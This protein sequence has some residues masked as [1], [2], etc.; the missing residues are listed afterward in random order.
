MPQ[1]LLRTAFLDPSEAKMASLLHFQASGNLKTP[2]CCG[3]I[4]MG[5]SA[6]TINVKPARITQYAGRARVGKIQHKMMAV[7]TPLA[8][9]RT[10]KI[11]R[12]IYH[13]PEAVDQYLKTFDR[14]LAVRRFGPSEKP[15]AHVTGHSLSL[16]EKHL[17]IADEHL[18]TTDALT[19]Y[20]TC[21]GVDLEEAG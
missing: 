2:I 4:T 12:R 14:L 17:A 7:E 3:S 10:Q 18:P 21:R 8:G 5:A 11:G 16:I 6:R 19:Q 1:Q 15:L 13:S 20:L 9:M